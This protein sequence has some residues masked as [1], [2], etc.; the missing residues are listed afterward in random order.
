LLLAAG[1]D[2]RLASLVADEMANPLCPSLHRCTFT[3]NEPIA[4]ARQCNIQQAQRLGVLFSATALAEFR[5]LL[6]GN[7]V[8]P[9]AHSVAQQQPVFSIGH[10]IASVI[11]WPASGIRHENYGELQPLRLMHRHKTNYVVI[12]SQY[13]GWWLIRLLLG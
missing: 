12:L 10:R 7:L 1:N 2:K 6:I 11:L 3:D 8:H 9:A 5:E 4:C 13:L